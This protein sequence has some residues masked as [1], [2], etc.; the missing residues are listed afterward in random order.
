M[1]GRCLSLA[2]GAKN[3]WEAK[4]TMSENPPPRPGMAPWAKWSMIG[5]G[6]CLTVAV[7]TTVLGAF[8]LSRNLKFEQISVTDKPDPPVMASANQLLPPRVGPFVRQSLSRGKPPQN[9]RSG[10]QGEPS[11]GWQ[12]T[13]SV[14]GRQV[15]VFVVPTDEARRNPNAGSPF[16]TAMQR[17][18]QNPNQGIVMSMKIGDRSL[19][20]VLWRKPNWTVMI[21]SE[22]DAATEFARAYRPA[23][24]G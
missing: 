20:M 21:Q 3:V 16:G 7:V 6:G 14:N 18:G 2:S 22:D 4:P 23:G 10:Q 17:G 8:L 12:A 11:R 9:G 5:C 1:A 19:Q 24:G 15:T 13:Y